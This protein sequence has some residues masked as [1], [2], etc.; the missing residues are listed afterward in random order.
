[1]TQLLY[2]RADLC[3][4]GIKF[5]NSSLLR[6]EAAERFPRRLRTSCRTVAWLPEEIEAWLQGR[7]VARDVEVA[8]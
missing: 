7:I 5:S 2:D 8:K 6:L 3:R 4:R 1:M